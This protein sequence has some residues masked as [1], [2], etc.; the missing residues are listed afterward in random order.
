MNGNKKNKLSRREFIK[1]SAGISLAPLA[2]KL[3]VTQLQVGTTPNI[4]LLVFD[5]LSAYHLSLYGY[6]RKTC[7]NM[8]QF[9]EKATVFHNHHAAANFTTPS[10]ASLLTGAY[11]WQHRSLTLTSRT[12][13]QVV[14]HNIFNLLQSK[15]YTAAYAQN[16]YADKL[17]FQFEDNI[18]HHQPTDNFNLMGRMVYNRFPVEEVDPV[19]RS[20]DSLLFTRVHPRGSLFISLLYSVTNILKSQLIYQD[21]RS[22]YPLG[23]PTI[24]TNNVYFTIDEVIDGVIT[25]VATLPTPFLSYIHL[26]PPH[27]PYRPNKNFHKLFNDKWEPVSKAKHPLGDEQRSDFPEKRQTYDEFIANL[28]HQI[29]KLLDY[30]EKTGLADNSYIILTSDHG[31]L[32][33]WGH[34]GHYTPL[35]FEP[36]LRVPLI[37]S[38][39]GQTTRK[40]VHTLTSSVDLL[41]TLLHISDLP[42]PASL[43]GQVLPFEESP[44]FY[45][46]SIWAL[47]AKENSIFGQLRKATLSLFKGQH[48]LVYYHGYEKYKNQYELYNIQEDP[49]ELA[50]IYGVDPKSIEMQAE[51]DR[52]FREI[53]QPI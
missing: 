40:D 27:S 26:M 4:I 42:I 34:L 24:S 36:L 41:P 5:T 15:Y 1:L 3:P 45:D 35:L 17:L 14:P 9:A 44:E 20:H 51:L 29:G 10:T 18:D 23:I 49:G 46:R 21:L 33:E 12:R 19:F 22:K 53:N 2:N 25:L 11:P 38:A 8:E 50:N 7:P 31:E 43:E 52:K 13:P 47:E 28:D 37:I 48:K 32:F 30:F 6:P 39:P 16:L